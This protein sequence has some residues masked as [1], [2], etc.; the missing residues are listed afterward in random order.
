ASSV[1]LEE[2]PYLMSA[3][4]VPRCVRANSPARLTEA[5]DCTEYGMISSRRGL[6]M[7]VMPCTSPNCE[8]SPVCD[9]RHTGQLDRSFVRPTSRWTATPNVCVSFFGYRSWLS[10]MRNSAIQPSES[11][12]V[13]TSQTASQEMSSLV[14]LYKYRS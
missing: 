1:R 14:S 12:E 7:P 6:L 4:T 13:F 11:I 8:A 2:R 5:F 9:R 3:P 10:G